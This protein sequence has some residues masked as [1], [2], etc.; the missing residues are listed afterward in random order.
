MEK[1]NQYWKNPTNTSDLSPRQDTSE[2][3]KGPMT[4]DAK[5]KNSQ[6]NLKNLLYCINNMYKV[7]QQLGPES[8]RETVLCGSSPT[9]G[10][11]GPDDTQETGHESN[12]TPIYTD[13]KKNPW[14]P[15]ELIESL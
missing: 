13:S 9:I 5:T 15:F 12:T 4:Q 2:D 1:S 8:R 10:Q 11:I 7:T 6:C 14:Q 3:V